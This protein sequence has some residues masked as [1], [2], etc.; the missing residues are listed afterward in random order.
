MAAFGEAPPGSVAAPPDSAAEFPDSAAE[1]SDF[2]A[3]FSDSAATWGDSGVNVAAIAV[4]KAAPAAD[5]PDFS[6]RWP[7]DGR[8]L[9]QFALAK[10]RTPGISCNYFGEKCEE[11]YPMFHVFVHRIPVLTSKH[12]VF[13]RFQQAGNRDF[14]I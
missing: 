8:I 7:D 2:A 10:V 12:L 14:A 6:V 4:E 1:F 13:S 5:L 3:L 9:Y 11:L